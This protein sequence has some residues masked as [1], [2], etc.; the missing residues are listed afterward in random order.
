[1]RFD[2]GMPFTTHIYLDVREEGVEFCVTD[3]MLGPEPP[4]PGGLMPAS[5]LTLDEYDRGVNI[6][7]WQNGVISLN[8]ALDAGQALD[9]VGMFI[10]AFLAAHVRMENP[11]KAD[12]VQ[13]AN[14][15]GELIEQGAAAIAGDGD[16]S[17]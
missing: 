2:V 13:I 7:F 4:P 10:A 6:R 5:S 12:P 14:Q 16:G 1:M 3:N 8:L 9:F 15:I 11:S 17:P